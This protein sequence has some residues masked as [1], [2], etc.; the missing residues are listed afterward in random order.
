[1]RGVRFHLQSFI[2]QKHGHNRSGSNRYI[3]DKT[4]EY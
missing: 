3:V 4:E 1:M 2:R